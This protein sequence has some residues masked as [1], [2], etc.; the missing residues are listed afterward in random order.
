MKNLVVLYGG[1]STAER[2][3]AEKLLRTPDTEERLALV[4]AATLAKAST[5]PRSTHFF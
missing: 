1:M 3:K 2:R 5:M 4:L